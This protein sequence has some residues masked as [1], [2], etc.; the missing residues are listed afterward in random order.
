MKIYVKTFNRPFYLDR[1]LRSI[2]F[3]VR[4]CDEVVVLDDGTL[5]KY[6]AELARRHPRVRW[7]RSNADDGKYQ[8]L[9]E[10]RFEEIRRRYEDAAGFWTRT[11]QMDSPKHFA[12]VEDDTWFVDQV[13]LAEIGSAM[14][15]RGLPITK[16]WWGDPGKHPASETVGRVPV[17]F[18][19]GMETFSPRLDTLDDIWKVWI[20]CM[21]V[22]RTD[23]WM[24]AFGGLQ[25][26]IDE[27]S[28]LRRIA[29]KLIREDLRLFGKTCRRA[30]YQGW[31]APGRSDPKYSRIGIRQ[32][33]YLDVLNDAWLSGE[34]DCMDGAPFDYTAE[35]I[36]GLLKGHLPQEQLDAWT[37][38]RRGDLGGGYENWYNE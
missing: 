17:S 27:E 33:L 37:A 31:A 15:L 20:V 4:G 28:Q 12:I 36:L 1:C 18:P 22:Y 11:I 14:E 6:Q 30:I 10:E 13:D 5:T 26:F 32:H 25:E 24:T 38:W 8:L 9:R 21:A 34:L 35:T 23:W 19:A 2:E 3:W 29:E 7:E 16:L